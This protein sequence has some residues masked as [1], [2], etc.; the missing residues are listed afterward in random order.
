[1]RQEKGNPAIVAGLFGAAAM[2]IPSVALAA[3][4][5]GSQGGIL[6]SPAIPFVLGCITGA[7]LTGA[8]ALIVTS[9]I[10]SNERKTEAMFD[11][12]DAASPLPSQEAVSSLEGDATHNSDSA[13]VTSPLHEPQRWGQGATRAAE[14][15]SRRAAADWRSTGGVDVRPYAR[16]QEPVPADV[17]VTD[18]SYAPLHVANDYA[19]IA[20]N[21]VRRMT[22]KERMASR[23]RGVAEILSERLGGDRFEGLPVIERADGSVGDVGTGWWNARL[24]DSVRHVGDVSG[25]EYGQE[26]LSIPTWVGKITS[27]GAFQGQG[28]HVG[29]RGES[30][31]SLRATRIAQSVAPVEQG[32]YPEKRTADDLDHEDAWEMAL[33]AMG[34]KI[35]QYQAAPVFADSVGGEETID[36]PDTLEGSTR[37]IPFK[38]PAGH[39]EV[40]DTSTYVDYLINEE[41]SQNPSHAVRKTSRDYL[42]VIEGGSQSFKSTGVLKRHGSSRKVTASSGYRP[43]HMAPAAAKEA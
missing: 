18:S 8:V 5:G 15:A 43:K 23:A 30:A 42:H 31:A 33:A 37:F 11:F 13:R 24:G 22:F 41:F 4:D 19:Q 38:T 7:A 20:E 10:A 27:E 14:R 1:M 9:K 3:P 28:G 40:V 32:A 26:D 6:E 39:P 29:A 17:S 34:E 12:P 36:D 21:Y 2:F 35:A 25:S 16:K